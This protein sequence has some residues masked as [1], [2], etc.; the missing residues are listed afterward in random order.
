M[1]TNSIFVSRQRELNQFK[2]LLEKEQGEVMDELIAL[3]KGIKDL[4][5]VRRTLRIQTDTNDRDIR[6]GLMELWERAQ[7]HIKRNFPTKKGRID[8]VAPWAA[9]WRY[10]KAY[11]RVRLV[12]TDTAPDIIEVSWSYPS[13]RGDRTG[14]RIFKGM[15]AAIRLFRK[16]VKE[17]S[18]KV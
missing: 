18:Q 15:D 11:S 6:E 12:I 4:L 14:H 16:K 13:K 5:L 1:V 17:V 2:R 7:P 8:I 9:I 10:E 3:Q